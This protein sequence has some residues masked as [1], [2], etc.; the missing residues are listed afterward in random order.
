MGYP[1]R[2]ET[3]LYKY[4][5]N[6][7]GEKNSQQTWELFGRV[8]EGKEIILILPPCSGQYECIEYFCR[9]TRWI[10]DKKKKYVVYG[11][12]MADLVFRGKPVLRWAAMNSFNIRDSVFLI[13]EESDKGVIW[14]QLKTVGAHFVFN[15]LEMEAARY[16]NQ[17]SF[18][19]KRIFAKVYV[20]DIFQY[21]EEAGKH[22]M[23]AQTWKKF[24]Q[25]TRRKKTI[26]FGAGRILDHFLYLYGDRYAVTEILDNSYSK[27]G[28]EMR[29]I[30]IYHAKHLLCHS[31]NDVVILICNM[32][33][34]GEIKQQLQAMNYNC[35]FDFL[36]MEKKKWYCVVET[37]WKKI[38]G[39]IISAISARTLSF[40]LSAVF[41]V[42]P[43]K[44]LFIRHNGKGYGDHEKYIA[45]EIM[46]QHLDYN[47]YWMVNNIYEKFPEGIIKVQNTFFNR[48]FH[49]S[50]AS[51]WINNDVMVDG[52]YKRRKQFYINTWHG[53]GISLKKFYLDDKK[54]MDKKSVQNV[55]YDSENADV[56]LAGSKEIAAIYRSAFAYRGKTYISGSPRVD[57]LMDGGQGIKDK[58]RERLG[59]QKGE[60]IVLVAPTF[61]RE[62]MVGTNQALECLTEQFF[63]V[64]GG[65]LKER[66]GGIWK[67]VVRTHPIQKIHFP[68]P[69]NVLDAT[70][71]ADVQELLCASDILVTDYSSIMFDMGY[72]Y[73]PVFLFAPDLDD[74]LATERKLYLDIHGLPFPL[75][76]TE[77]ELEFLISQF[78][79]EI[80]TNKLDIFH[81][82]HAVRED[83]SA[84]ERAVEIIKQS[85]KIKK[86]IFPDPANWMIG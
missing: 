16:N 69:C 85:K 59:I 10:T 35:C 36:Q 26:A 67:I 82:M 51:Y 64:L 2:L 25:E 9:H 14:A 52:I 30:P 4:I 60:N 15:I 48:I 57:I 72:A 29:G 6:R 58:I 34:A 3:E 73:K 61:R 38:L 79:P 76:Q 71:Y 32:R 50:T 68:T 22:S 78:D 11:D 12:G 23:P 5:I 54:N 28:K 33:H 81:E 47:L 74:Y 13:Y 77:K 46:R 37:V 84:S 65:S 19:R 20:P 1:R 44:I 56:Y 21:T 18:F 31:R 75:A 53:T 70:S 45:E 27:S 80:Y 55:V 49:M 8:S 86:N 39:K 24:R 42:E 43:K 40:I 17:G 62:L 66:F 7:D 83:G 41:P 63:Q